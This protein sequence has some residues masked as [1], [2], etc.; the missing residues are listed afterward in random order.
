MKRLVAG[1][2]AAFAAVFGVLAYGWG[3]R[4]SGADQAKRETALEAADRYAKTTKDIQNADLGL[5]AT[6][7]DRIK[8][9]REFADK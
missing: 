5:G 4:R 1:I 9:L 3:Q 6:D 7:A 8:R 2:A